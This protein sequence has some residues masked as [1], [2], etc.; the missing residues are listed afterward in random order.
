MAEGA[1]GIKQDRPPGKSC[2][3]E[4][5]GVFEVRHSVGYSQIV[6]FFHYRERRGERPLAA[7]T[8]VEGTRKAMWKRR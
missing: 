2:V 6:D 8:F 7:S 5:G 1:R 3:G 4:T